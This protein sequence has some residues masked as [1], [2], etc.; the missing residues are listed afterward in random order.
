M[1]AN[2]IL[3]FMILWEM[4]LAPKLQNKQNKTKTQAKAI[5]DKK[6][7]H[8]TVRSSITIAFF[9]EIL[10]LRQNGMYI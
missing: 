6:K 8:L 7:K 2:R 3:Y 5:K 9:D 10:A 1:K 4:I